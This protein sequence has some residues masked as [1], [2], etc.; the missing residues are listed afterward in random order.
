MGLH[1]GRRIIQQKGNGEKE[2]KEQEKSCI[3]QCH[4]L[5]SHRQ[6]PKD[7]CCSTTKLNKQI[8]PP[9]QLT[10]D[11]RRHRTPT[12]IILWLDDKH[13]EELL[14]WEV[15]SLHKDRSMRSEGASPSIQGR[16]DAPKG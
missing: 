3:Q 6:D 15:L 7:F 12:G 8:H 1:A 2:G 13:N 14:T 11:G 10:V 4:I 16:G 9:A 5:P